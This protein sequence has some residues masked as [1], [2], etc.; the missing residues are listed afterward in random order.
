VTPKPP[1]HDSLLRLRDAKI[2]LLEVHTLKLCTFYE[3]AIPPYAILSHRWLPNDDEVT[4]QQIGDPSGCRHLRGFLK[5]ELLCNQAIKD[6]YRYAW[7]DTCCIDKSNS[8]E[9][10]EAINSMYA[11]YK[12]SAVCYAYLA[13]INLGSQDIMD[14][15]WWSRAWYVGIMPILS[16][17]TSLTRCV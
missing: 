13:D 15:I 2:R 12:R 8:T 10:S 6:G 14:S 17:M 9:L 3:D 4:F 7:I 1:I 11:W 16:R 5:I